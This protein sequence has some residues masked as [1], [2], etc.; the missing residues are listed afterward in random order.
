MQVKNAIVEIEGEPLFAL[1]TTLDYL[2]EEMHRRGNVQLKSM[3]LV[4]SDSAQQMLRVHGRNG[5]TRFHHVLELTQIKGG[6]EFRI[7]KLSVHKT[8]SSSPKSN[9]RSAARGNL[10]LA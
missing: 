9:P 1:E 4:E 10:L 3:E 8:P 7:A 2:R 6:S 5:V